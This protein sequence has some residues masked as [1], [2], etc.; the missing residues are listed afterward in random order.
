MVDFEKMTEIL[1]EFISEEYDNTST[2]AFD[3]FFEF[4]NLAIPYVIGLANDHI[5]VTEEGKRI[6]KET[7]IEL[8]EI[9]NTDPNEDYESLSDLSDGIY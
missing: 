7:Y 9:F 2:D 6:I 1:Y 4:N 3:T 5:M 8:C